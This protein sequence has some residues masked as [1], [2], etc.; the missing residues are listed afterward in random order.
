MGVTFAGSTTS[1][2]APNIEAGIYEARFDGVAPKTVP[3]SQFGNGESLEWTFTLFE[4]GKVLY[5]EGEPIEVTGLTSL[6]MNVKSKTVPR[7][8]KYL[9]G[10]MTKQE[11]ALFEA[12]QPTPAEA[13]VGR[14]CQLIISIKDTGWPKVDDV[15]PAKSKKG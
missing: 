13:L 6:S 8:V 15:L 5:D 10:L 9:K 12:E 14:F 3:N 1:A 7:G 2:G 4:D 11:Y